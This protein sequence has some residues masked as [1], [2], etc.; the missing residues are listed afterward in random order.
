MG[1][2]LLSPSLVTID[3]AYRLQQAAAYY[4][5]CLEVIGNLKAGTMPLL[6]ECCELRVSKRNSLFW[7]RFSSIAKFITSQVEAVVFIW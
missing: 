6:I 7:E 4:M 5:P 3:L 2:L 1:Y